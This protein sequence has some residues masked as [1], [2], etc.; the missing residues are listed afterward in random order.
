MVFTFRMLTVWK[1]RDIN[2]SMEMQD[3]VV[4]GWAEVC[5]QCSGSTDQEPNDFG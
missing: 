1:G 5:T 2:R 3:D 4:R